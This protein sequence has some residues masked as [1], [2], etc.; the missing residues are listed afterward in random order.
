MR[1][2]L[3]ENL[4]DDTGRLLCLA[5]MSEAKSVHSEQHSSV[6]RLETVTHVREGPGYDHRHGVV[7]IGTPH[8]L[9]DVHLLY[10]TCFYFVF[11]I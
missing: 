4:S 1:M 3:T 10:P 2:V 9:V 5:G 7:D 6:Y 11:H 8:L